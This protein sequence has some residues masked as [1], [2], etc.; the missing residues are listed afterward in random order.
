MSRHIAPSWW[1]IIMT[2]QTVYY[3]HSYVFQIFLNYPETISSSYQERC[4]CRCLLAVIDQNVYFWWLQFRSNC[5]TRYRASKRIIH[6]VCCCFVQCRLLC[7]CVILWSLQVFSAGLQACQPELVNIHCKYCIFWRFDL[8]LS[9][10]SSNPPLNAVTPLHFQ[11][12]NHHHI[13]DPVTSL[14]LIIQII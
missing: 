3:I 10:F 11:H 12:L 13:C 7:C 1:F 4:G 14:F 8:L 9:Q 5:L 6:V 2:P